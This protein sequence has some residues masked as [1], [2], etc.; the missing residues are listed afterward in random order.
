MHLSRI[1][2]TM[3]NFRLLSLVFI[4]ST[5]VSS[6]SAL[7][8]VACI[9]NSITS[10]Y[11][12][13]GATYVPQL[14]S[15]LGSDYEVKNFGVSGTTLLKNGNSPY[16][17]T[18]QFSQ[19]LAYRADIVTIKLGTNDSK[20]ANWEV[21]R[22]EFSK[23]YEALIDTLSSGTVKPKIFLVLPVP[24]FYHAAT[25]SW[26]I[27]DSIINLILPLIKEIGADRNLPVLD[28]NTPLTGHAEYFTIDGI[29]PNSAGADSIAQVLYRGIKSGS[30]SAQY[31]A[32]HSPANNRQSLPSTYRLI[33]AN[34]IERIVRG[35]QEQAVYSVEIFALNGV[36]QT[37][38]LLNGPAQ[39]RL[40]LQKQIHTSLAPT[41]VTV[42]KVP[43]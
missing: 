34:D 14:Q 27:R 22:D 36:R 7:T 10:G 21:H 39:V 25:V 26:G 41:C 5:L 42:Q 38:L 16:W 20:P 35:M 40:N 11:Q 15:L 6:S 12:S 1:L 18:G 2:L 32:L 3:K 31:G 19:A 37:S 8:K 30:T 43:K 9:G 33:R 17:K 28:A 29:H 13:T 4:S 24:A 23:D